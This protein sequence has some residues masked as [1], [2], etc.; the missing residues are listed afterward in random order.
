[1]SNQKHVD[2]ILTGHA[3]PYFPP[4]VDDL[5]K[6]LDEAGAF[7]GAWLE[8]VGQT[9][10]GFVREVS[11]PMTSD[12]YTWFWSLEFTSGEGTVAVL[13]PW[14]QDW[15]KA[16]GT[17]SDRGIAVHTKDVNE[18]TAAQ[19]VQKLVDAVRQQRELDAIEAANR[20]RE[21]GDEEKGSKPV[22]LRSLLVISVNGAETPHGFSHVVGER[23]A[24]NLLACEEWPEGEGVPVSADIWVFKT[25]LSGYTDLEEHLNQVQ[26]QQV[27]LGDLPT[28]IASGPSVEVQLEPDYY[29]DVFC[30]GYKANDTGFLAGG[31]RYATTDNGTKVPDFLTLDETKAF[32]LAGIGLSLEKGQLVHATVTPMTAWGENGRFIIAGFDFGRRNENDSLSN[33]GV[34]VQ[35]NGH[36]NTYHGRTAEETREFIGV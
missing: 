14:S 16:D 36:S 34:M 19:V 18:A 3:G 13:I 8:R 22:D 25:P 21:Q 7:N 29:Y 32:A 9:I 12:G 33:F 27:T 30:V 24:A 26:G 15:D 4:S 20:R 6:Q 5:R 17:Q 28:L 2:A 35:H 31:S 1:M 11:C 10:K 23:L